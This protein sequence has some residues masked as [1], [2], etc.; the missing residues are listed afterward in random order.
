MNRTADYL[1]TVILMGT[2]FVS[3]LFPVNEQT[4]DSE[5][6]QSNFEEYTQPIPGS[7]EEID[8]VPIEGGTYFRGSPE[9]EEGHSED[10][11]PR[12][13]VNVDSFW[14]GKYEITWDQYELFVKEKLSE[15]EQQLPGEGDIQMD[16]D[17]VSLP[18]PPY[19]D[20]SFGMGKNGYPA[21]NMT[22][23]AAVMYAKWLTAKTGH[24]YRL[25]TEAEWEYACRAGSETAYHFGDDP[26]ELDQYAWYKEN[27]DRAYQKIGTK[28]PNP[29]G[30]YDIHG[31]VAEWTMDQ[32][33]D[34]A[35]EEYEGETADNPWIKPTEVYPRSVRGGS[36]D[37]DPEQL[38]CAERRGSE[39]RW[40]ERDPQFPKSVWW[41][42]DASFVGF[43]LVRP[44]TTP[45]DEEIEEYWLEAM[46][47]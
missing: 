6:K 38:R 46:E 33:V 30:L 29:L 18:T 7:D 10:E 4:A 44:E 37:D 5:K 35:Y 43:R 24:F 47:E 32:Y 1:S 42:T 9:S 19:T 31:N 17:A 14:M 2:F 13:E 41:F 8:L 27:S 12:H 16:A 15:L 45:P 34:E 26:S 39:P 11:S 40:K 21:I 28:E 36:W 25:P 20:M 3:V 23:Y 22:Q